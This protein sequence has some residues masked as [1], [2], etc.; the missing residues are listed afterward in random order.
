MCKPIKINNKSGFTL[1]EMLVVV[2]VFMVVIMI[3]TDSFNTLFIQARKLSGI[4]ES[5]IE[6]VIGL[7]MLRHDLDQ[8]GYGLPHAFDED[9]TLPPIY[10]EATAELAKK[11]NDAPSGVPRAMVFQKYS[12]SEDASGAKYGGAPGSW[13]LGVKGVSLTNDKAVTKWTYAAYSSSTYGTKPPK[14][15]ASGNF[16]SGDR[17]AIIRRTFKDGEFANRLAYDTANRDNYWTVYSKDGFTPAFAPKDMNEIVYAYG[18]GLK[19]NDI[20]MPFNRA[21][22]FIAVPKTASSLPAVCAPG[23]GV[24]YKA[25]V[26]Q[27]GGKLN[28]MPLLDCVADMQ[29]VLGWDLWD[30]SGSTDGQ[31]GKIDTWSSPADASG[32]ITAGGVV[33]SSKVVEAL[34]SAEKIRKSLRIVK[35]YVLAQIGRRDQNYTN[36]EFINVS[37]IGE[38]SYGRTFQLTPE[39][40]HYRWKVYSVVSRPRNLGLN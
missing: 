21:D 11:L 10:K 19:S 7:E 35:V 20:G 2:S 40:R 9:E 6:G 1:V 36:S 38:S 15:W 3:A 4:E 32:N 30:E 27:N 37:G 8:A 23:T 13:Y 34:A 25:T 26:N 39:M 31:D 29:I 18:L 33:S 16:E 12:S 5:N 17:V 22:F 14:I 24:L 28:Y